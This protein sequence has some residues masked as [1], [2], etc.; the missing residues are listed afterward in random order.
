[1]TGRME[2]FCSYS[3]L[4]SPRFELRRACSPATIYTLPIRLLVPIRTWVPQDSNG[5]QGGA[6][7]PCTNLHY[8]Y[9]FLFELGFPKIRMTG[10]MELRSPAPIYT[11]PIRLFVPIR[12]WV[13]Q[14]S[15]D[16]QGGASLPCTN[17]HSPYSI[18]FSRFELGLPEI[19]AAE[20]LPILNHILL[21]KLGSRR[22]K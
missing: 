13:P 10:R 17:V 8:P 15:N 2:L 3:N 5:G 14:D 7:L 21:I 11:L 4:G 18:T 19:R 9:F 20:G 12:T 6:S 22:G 16:G 1:M